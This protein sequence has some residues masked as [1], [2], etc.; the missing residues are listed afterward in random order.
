MPDLKKKNGNKAHAYI[1]AQSSP[2]IVFS[3]VY[4][5]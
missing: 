2:S 3:I 1:A 4:P 5:R